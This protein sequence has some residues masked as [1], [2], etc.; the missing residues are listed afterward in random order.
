M[1]PLH[2]NGIQV[3]TKDI[4][5]GLT[6]EG[7]RLAIIDSQLSRLDF[8][9]TCELDTWSPRSDLANGVNKSARDTPRL[10]D[11]MI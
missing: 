6:G 1:R 11:S 8:L 9:P 2:R 5:I 3:C 7:A 4:G 10:A